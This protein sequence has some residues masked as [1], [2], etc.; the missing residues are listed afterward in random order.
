LFI[1]RDL[2][3]QNGDLWT[4]DNTCELCECVMGVIMC[5]DSFSEPYCGVRS[6]LIT[7]KISHNQALIINMYVNLN[8]FTIFCWTLKLFSSYNDITQYCTTS[9]VFKQKLI[10]QYQC[11]VFDVRPISA[12]RRGSELWRRPL[13]P[14]VRPH[15]TNLHAPQPHWG[16]L[17]GRLRVHFRRQLPVLCRKLWR[18][19]FYAS[20]LALQRRHLCHGKWPR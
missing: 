12:G 10:S 4:P 17:P 20:S 7:S 5:Q 14:E 8:D 9:I 16:H 19:L 6:F 13:L 2:V 15:S 1:T 3:F 11:W 18:E